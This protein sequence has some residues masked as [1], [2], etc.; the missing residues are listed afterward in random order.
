MSLNTSPYPH[1]RAIGASVMI[2]V[3]MAYHAA[4]LTGLFDEV[5]YHLGDKEGYKQDAIKHIG[6]IVAY[7]LT[8]AGAG[9]WYIDAKQSGSVGIGLAPEGKNPDVTLQCPAVLFPGLGPVKEERM[10][11]FVDS[12]LIKISGNDS[13]PKQDLLRIVCDCHKEICGMSKGEPLW[14]LEDLPQ[15]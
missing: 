6:R 7:N 5:A 4:S 14:L 9:Q 2:E 1:N 15:E 11:S 12:R 13:I 3:L 8:D 10:R